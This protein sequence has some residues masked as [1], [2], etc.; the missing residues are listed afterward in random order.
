MSVSLAYIFPNILP[1][2]DLIF[3][4]AQ[5]FEQLVFLRPV[6]DDSP[7]EDTPFLQKMKDQQG[8]NG[9]INYS[10]P[11]PL[12]EDRDRFLTLLRDIRSRP[13]DYTG[14]L[15]N[16]SASLS[17]PVRQEEQERSIIDT[18]LR[19]TG[20]QTGSGEHT[21]Q[22]KKEQAKNTSPALLW[23]ARLLLKLGEYMDQDQVEIRRNLDRMTCQQDELFKKLREGQEEDFPELAFPSF[24]TDNEISFKQQQ[25]RLKAWS[26]LFALSLDR[27][28]TT[29]FISS[30]PDAVES[31]LEHYRQE[32]EGTAKRLLN[33]P[34][35][36]FFDEGHDALLCRDRFQEEASE[37]ITTIKVLSTASADSIFP[38]EGE[39]AWG[40]LLE[41]YYPVAQHG[42]R[43]LT[44]YFLSG[45]HP[46]QFFF[47]TFVAQNDLSAKK[48]LEAN[49]AGMVVGLLV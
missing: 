34:L 26:R 20:I 45:I 46:Q 40:D 5:F 2:D 15:G 18:L 10:C 35:P 8:D 37:L 27:F 6:E 17:V 9:Y 39:K 7:K 32:Y 49:G 36:A 43:T 30:I 24:T 38:E 12:A 44:L 29:A 1:Q 41:R 19:Q 25:L 42:R 31:L 47:E 21:P 28:E 33:L 4:L 16:L 48:V 3:P 23:Q 14:H 22:A 13:D 11:V